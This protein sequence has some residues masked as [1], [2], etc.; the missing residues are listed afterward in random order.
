MSGMINGLGDIYT[1]VQLTALV[2]QKLK[3]S[4]HAP[5][6]V[7][8]LIDYVDRFKSC[9]ARAEQNIRDYGAILK[10]HDGLK[11]DMVKL[12]QRCEETVSKL[13]RIATSYEKIV[14]EEGAATED[15]LSRKQW[16]RAL[17][18]VY[19]QIK[20]TTIGN[21]INDLR[22]QVSEHMQFL[23]DMGQHLLK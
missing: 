6:E 22:N 23:Q 9:V 11:S 3:A 2:A 15:V 16:A 4:R 19:L 14:R 5:S 20:W 17:K 18:T 8:V 1:L 7:L 12:L 21:A 10:P 13:Q